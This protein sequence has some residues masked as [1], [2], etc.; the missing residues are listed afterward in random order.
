LAA[1]DLKKA[2]I[3]LIVHEPGIRRTLRDLLRS[4]GAED[5]I[6]GSK[7]EDI[8]IAITENTPD[9]I[10]LGSSFPDGDVAALI[11]DVRHNKVG[12]DPFLPIISLTPEPTEELVGSIA[13]SGSDDLLVYPLSPAQLLTR[14]EVLIEKRKPFV[15]TK[16]YIGPDRRGVEAYS[17]GQ[18]EIQRI[19][20]PNTL[21]A[22]V[23]G[24]LSK[25]QLE[26][27]IKSSLGVVN[28]QRLGRSGDHISWLIHR[29]TA[30][31][32]SETGGILEPKIADFLTELIKLGNETT[33][34]LPGTG[35]EHV[36]YLCE[37]LI[38]VTKRMA[39]AG[40]EAKDTDKALLGEL[41]NAFKTAFV[42]ADDGNISKKIRD[43]LQKQSVAATG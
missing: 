27:A 43:T 12:K 11:K 1:I 28:G 16:S 5:L 18:G 30:G 10:I 38:S 15:V 22:S 29:I 40:A 42:S 3:H 14:I 21:R 31:Y 20:V 7:F 9:L 39:A 37:T 17:Q 35:F 6:L 24:D 26:M 34:R 32:E 13:D 23:T 33:K 2:R 25:E 4:I 41:A 8:R 19:D 36:S